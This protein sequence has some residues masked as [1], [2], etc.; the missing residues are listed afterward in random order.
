[1]RTLSN[2]IAQ[3]DLELCK[4]LVNAGISIDQPLNNCY[5]CTP[6]L[7]ALGL[8]HSAIARYFIE[9]GASTNGQVCSCIK[10]GQLTYK[11]YTA[12][13]LASRRESQV[14]LLR[15]LLA[16]DI[17]AGSPAFR[18]PVSPIHIAIACNN[19]TALKVLL[20]HAQ[21]TILRSETQRADTDITI[22][23]PYDAG[24]EPSQNKS[25]GFSAL[26]HSNRATY[27]AAIETSNLKWEW[28]LS[29]PWMKQPHSCS[30][31]LSTSTIS[32]GSG[33]HIAAYMNNLTAVNSLLDSGADVD[34]LDAGGHTPLHIAALQGHQETMSALLQHGANPVAQ[35][36][37]GQTPAMLAI[38]AGHMMALE[39]LTMLQSS[40]SHRDVHGWNL[41]HHAATNSPKAF[42]YLLSKGMSPYAINHYGVTPVELGFLNS[43]SQ[44]A[45]QTLLCN[46]DLSLHCNPGHIS[47]IEWGKPA[48]LTLLKLILRRL[49]KDYIAK[50]IDLNTNRLGKGSP[51]SQVA[52]T[53]QV[54]IIEILIQA[55]ANLEVERENQGTPLI[56][57]CLWGRLSAVRCLV[58]A[59]ASVF[60]KKAGKPCSALQAARNFPHIVHWLLGQR[61]TE[62]RKIELRSQDVAEHEI[63]NWS[64]PR[65]AEVMIAGLYSPEPT[66]PLGHV[67]E[68]TRLKKELQG[69][70]VVTNCFND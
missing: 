4:S 9:E 56:A 7:W 25:Q 62:Q 31:Y 68:L 50:E 52:K 51:L 8:E 59:G 33:L 69:K 30:W 13:H 55:G 1:L 70:V 36:K 66:T 16:K 38:S 35:N 20:E 53:D 14:D 21:N 64:G 15:L 26:R 54:D 29:H 34:S 57:A 24:I 23:T 19:N 41:L 6:V 45:F 17:E 47:G 42:S 28:I 67:I 49:P 22:T 63:K 39:L 58:R 18:G 46:W 44:P 40:L 32:S 2:A 43:K 3:G 65:S 61:W 37:F 12:V 10:L 27:D 60:G 11:G 48:Q 5:G